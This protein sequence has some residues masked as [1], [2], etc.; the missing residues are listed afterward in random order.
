[1]KLVVTGVDFLTQ[2]LVGMQSG[3]ARAPL[4]QVRRPLGCLARGDEQAVVRLVPVDR[5]FVHV[6]PGELVE[7]QQRCERR[8]L[9]ECRV[10]RV[11]VVEDT[12][13]D[14]GI[15]RSGVVE[16]FQ[17][18]LAVERTLGSFGID[19]QYVV[20]LRGQLRRNAAVVTA[21]DLEH[22]SRRLG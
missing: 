12:P 2:H 19:R 3:V 9:V 14:D 11:D 20:T 10:E 5:G 4:G 13:P 6:I 1:M 8:E 21:A 22:A 17:C 7:D 18:D 16:V 15:E